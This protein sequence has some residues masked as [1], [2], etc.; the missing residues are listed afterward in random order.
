[1][2]I[3]AANERPDSIVIDSI[4][5]ARVS[6]PAFFFTPC[7]RSSRSFIS[8]VTL[9]L[10]QHLAINLRGD[11][12][13]KHPHRLVLRI[14]ARIAGVVLLASFAIPRG[15]VLIM[16]PNAMVEIA[17]QAADRRFVADIR[18][19]KAAGRQAADVIRRLDQHHAL[20]HPMSLNGGN[21]AG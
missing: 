8:G 7:C 4:R 6:D 21:D 1:M 10:G 5:V 15:V 18:R 19:A 20:A 12:R 16:L 2:N 17:G 3:L 14:V 13:L 9:R 11:M